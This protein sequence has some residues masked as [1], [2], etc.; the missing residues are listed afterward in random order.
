[1]N[2]RITRTVLCTAIVV[3]GLFLSRPARAQQLS[4]STNMV[5]WANLGTFNAEAGVSI[6]R[7]FSIHAGFRYN[8]WT[9]RAGNPDD[10]FV[11]PNGDSEKQFENRKQ[12]YNLNLRFWPWYVYDGWWIYAKGQYT[13]YNRGGLINHWA[14]EGDAFGGGLGFGYT[15]MLHKHWNLEFGAGVWAGKTKYTK[16]RCTNCGVKEDEG[17]KFFILPDDVMIS[18]VFVF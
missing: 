13:E 1:M 10:R 16:Y 9:F 8:P 7:H 17:E 3:L 4:F 2:S 5:E 11:D 12:S 14:E 18:I 15:Y 6:A